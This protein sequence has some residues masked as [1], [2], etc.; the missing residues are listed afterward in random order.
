MYLIGQLL[1]SL[2][3]LPVGSDWILA[4]TVSLNENSDIYLLDIEPR[5]PIVINFG[6]ELGPWLQNFE[7]SI[8]YFC[9]IIS[10]VLVS[11]QNMKI[12][13]KKLFQNKN[14]CKKYEPIRRILEASTSEIVFKGMSSCCKQTIFRHFFII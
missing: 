8:V 6:L 1:E 13:R 7:F 10:I 3:L 14:R 4:F 2:C 5:S 12:D 9:S 11:V